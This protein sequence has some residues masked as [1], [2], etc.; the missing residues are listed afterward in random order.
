VVGVAIAHPS[1]P[2]GVYAP[3]HPE[4]SLTLMTQ[5]AKFNL[6]AHNVPYD[7]RVME[8]VFRK[9]Q[10][11]YKPSSIWPWKSDTKI[12]FK[13]MASEGYAGQSWSLK[14]AQQ[15]VLGWTETNEVE[16]DD[17][18]ATNGYVKNGKVMKGEMHRAPPHILGKYG[19]LDA[20]STLA[21]YEHLMSQAEP[22]PDLVN[23]VENEFMV[24]ARLEVEEYFRG[25]YVDPKLQDN[26]LKVEEAMATLLDIFYHD[27]E[28]TRYI[29]HYNASIVNKLNESEPPR[30]TKTGK[31]S[32]RYI[33]WKEKVD[34][35]RG[36]NHFNPNSKDQLAWL[37]YDCIFE[38]TDVETSYDWKHD[39]VRTFTVTVGDT[40]HT[41]NGTTTGK[42][43]VDKKIL[44]KLGKAGLLLARYNE[45]NKILGYMN[46][47]QASLQGDVHHTGLNLYG[48]LTGRCS[49]GSL[50]E[51]GDRTVVKNNLQQLPKIR[52][53]LE[54]LKP[55]PGYVF[56]Q[57]DVDALEPVVLAELSGD[58]AMMN[59]YGPGAKPN[60]IYLFVGA[61]IPALR[62]EVCAYGYDPLNPTSD[63]IRITKKKAKRIRSICKVLHLSAGYGAGPRKI[64]ET[65]I[66]SDIDISLDDVKE[67]HKAYW[68]LFGGVVDYQNKLKAEWADNGGWFING[69]GMPMPVSKRLEKDI[70]NRCIQSTGHINLLTYLK[71]LQ[72]LRLAS[73]IEMHPIVVDFHD[74]TIWEV[75]IDQADAA[76]ELFRQTWDL[77]NKEL[78]GIIPLS[79]EPEICESFVDFK[80]EGDYRI[81]EILN[82]FKLEEVG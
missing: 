4:S 45:L 20:Q 16:L 46:S 49:G 21:L 8:D 30:Y 44:P 31:E 27:S 23:I 52:E 76:L 24:L 11:N 14:S 54:C 41:V 32:V 72:Q 64:W 43:V 61:S 56:V 29:K 65:L 66:Q 2:M 12:L 38:S 36:V 79:G 58:S 5:L 13:A 22:F 37:F 74:E 51:L 67:I 9:Y 48:T 10:P 80:V 18:L 82:E 15:T 39:P 55:R 42:R 57:M 78:G 77:T 28:A 25:L 75:P 70:L 71:H 62:D 7:A 33:R 60:D 47:M 69:R 40:T 59:L 26:I 3:V 17:W 1:F 19:A 81:P 68:K 34:K 53:Y 63:A 6:I 50:R 35:A 73:D